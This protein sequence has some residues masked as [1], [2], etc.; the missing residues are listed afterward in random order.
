MSYDIRIWTTKEYKEDTDISPQSDGKNW[1]LQVGQSA[2]VDNEDIPEEVVGYLSGIQYVID[3]HLEP[4]GA[5]K[6]A[7]TLL[8]KTAKIL[9]K[10]YHGVIEDPQTD[11]LTLP[12]GV[13]RYAAPPKQTGDG[14]PRAELSMHWMLPND[15]PLLKEG[16]I[17]AL[18]EY[19]SRNLPE[20]MPRR[21]GQF[22]PP[23]YKIEE[24]GKE[25]FLNFYKEHKGEIV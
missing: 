11:S 25:H 21:Y 4:A 22:E 13:K 16:G 8:Q 20:A 6:A 15:S 12:S 24:N 2:K 10:K 19:F 1:L 17:N 7:H 23:K 5:P 9:A 3:L 18:V 14:K